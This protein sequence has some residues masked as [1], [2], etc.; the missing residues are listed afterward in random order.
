MPFDNTQVEIDLSEPS[1]A[2]LSWI[3]R[4]REAWPA[5]FAWDF[6][7]A[8]SCAVGIGLVYWGISMIQDYQQ[9]SKF[10]RQRMFCC[11]Q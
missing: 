10:D 11:A 9:A 3:L 2:G 5:N 6:R 1:L 4:H 7:M 8:R